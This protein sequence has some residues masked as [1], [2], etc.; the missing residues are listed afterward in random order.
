MQAWN[1][2]FH[3]NGNT[4]GTWLRGDPRGF[5]DRKHRQHFEG[6]YKNPPPIGMYD[7]LLQHSKGLMRHPPLRLSLPQRLKVRD[8]MA[9]KLKCD[10][11]ELLALAVDDHHFHLLA[12]FP[13]ARPKH[14][15]GRA[16]MN[17]SMMMRGE[18]A[19]SRLWASG[20]RTLPIKDRA[21]Q[22]NVFNYILRHAEQGAAIWSFR[23]AKPE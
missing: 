4:Y 15:I 18:K 13:D 21:H 5:R 7:A 16:K 11:V 8:A 2:W 12:R 9:E 20:C 19:H 22:K 6:D 1:G 14:W 23:D 10:G 17:A 3:C